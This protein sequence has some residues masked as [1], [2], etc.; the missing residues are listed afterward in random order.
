MA[1][2]EGRF[3]VVEGIDG[4]GSTTQVERL[5]AVLAARGV[6]VRRTAEPTTGPVGRLIRSGLAAPDGVEPGAVRPVFDWVT[7]AL[8]FA[9]DRAHHNETLIRP[10]L[11][12]GAWVVSDRYDLSSLA[13]QSVTA[14]AEQPVLPWIRELNRRAR[15]PDLT[16]VLDVDPAV[17]SERR[18]HRGGAPEI[19]E[20][21][22]V[23]H[24]LAELYA[25][26][27][28]LVPGDRLVHVP[29]AGP[30]DEVARA[31]VATVE[32]WLSA[33]GEA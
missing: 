8:L 27:A 9:A 24:R 18:R 4:S 21:A 33:G 5:V 12:A 31:V 28:E 20:V 16:I 22:G 32:P 30:V 29:G 17:A 3:I 26:A 15:R 2:R 23:Q 25:R 19:Y 7:F 14:T 11:A 1:P 6:D 10:A 13:Y